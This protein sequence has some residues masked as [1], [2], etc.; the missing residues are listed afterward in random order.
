MRNLK[1]AFVAMLGLAVLA[2]CNRAPSGQAGSS[3]DLTAASN[4]KFLADYAARDGVKKTADGMFY[5]VIKSGSGAHANGPQDGATVRYKG[6]LINGKVFDETQGD[7]PT[8]PIGRLIPGWVEA[9][10]MMKE[11][12]E[13]ELVIPSALG[14]GAEGAG[15]SIPPGQTLVFDMTLLKVHS[16][17]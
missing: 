10:S 14:Y 5:R 8:F 16:G 4:S 2:A 3:Y 11:G 1:I 12:D 7:P 13:W 9:L 15:D 17:Q 6:S